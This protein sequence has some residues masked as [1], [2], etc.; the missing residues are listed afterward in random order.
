MRSP[1][2]QDIPLEA[3]PCP[4]YSLLYVSAFAGPFKGES[5]WQPLQTARRV[6][7][8]QEK[9]SFVRVKVLHGT[10]ANGTRGG[11]CGHRGGGGGLL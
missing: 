8:G 2:L 6:V 11:R 10:N 7:L 1:S 3:P 9:L 4:V 5:Q